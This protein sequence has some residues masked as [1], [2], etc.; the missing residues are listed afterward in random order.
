[1]SSMLEV[2]DSRRSRSKSPGGRERSRSR[3][4]SRDA[5][6]DFDRRERDRSSDHRRSTKYSGS[7]D[8]AEDERRYKDQRSSR[9]SY[10]AEEEDDRRK[11][12]RTSRAYE[13]QSEDDRYRSSK[14]GKES[15]RRDWSPSDDEKERRRTTSKRDSNR[16]RSD[17][18][19]NDDRRK[20]NRKH[21]DDSESHSEDD[22][23]KYTNGRT[24]SYSQQPAHGYVPPPGAYAEI[25]PK[26]SH[27][28]SYGDSRYGPPG[29]F[30]TSSGPPPTQRTPSY[31]GPTAPEYAKVDQYKYA[32]PDANASYKYK[33][34]SSQ[35]QYNGRRQEYD[36]SRPSD[37][38]RIKEK[39]YSDDRYE[40]REPHERKYYEDDD[41]KDHRRSSKYHSDKYGAP[42]EDM[43]KNL[44]KLAFAGG[45]G[46]ATLGVA[47]QIS[48]DG[49]KPPASPLLEAYKG[50]Y[51]SISPMPTAL[52]LANHK[53]D[54]DLSD[55]DIGRDDDSDDDIKRK[56][57]KLEREKAEYEASREKEREKK[58]AANEYETRE[59]RSSGGLET[60]E[61]R[62]RRLSN[63]DTSLEVREPGG[64]RDRSRDRRGTN[65][66]ISPT[67]PSGKKKVSF[68][69][70]TSD[71][72]RIAKALQGTGPA[73]PRP[74]LQILPGLTTDE[75]FAL[76][77]EYKNHAKVQGQGINIA[78]H[79]KMRVPGNLGKACYTTAL[80]RWESE[81]YWANSFYQGGASRREL[82]IESLMGRSNHD[83][84]EIKNC[85]KDKK[86]GDDLERCIRT[87]LRA[88]KFRMAILL[89]LEERR[90]PESTPLDPRLIKADVGAL[91]NALDSQGG[92]SDMLKIIVLRSDM[93][94]REVLRIFEGTYGIHFARAMI[95]KSRN[96][97]GETLAHILNGALNRPMR[98]A[99]L[100]RQAISETAPGKERTELL[101]SRL[102]RLHWEPKHLDKVKQVYQERYHVAVR[103]AIKREVWDGMRTPEG[104]LCAEFCIELADS[105]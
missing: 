21:R 47:T 71:A 75:L 48:H 15:R 16:K 20:S 28:M 80:G 78:K 93:H 40:T 103:Q 1:M 69:D 34:S 45:L 82:L 7:D 4:H 2:R 83:I 19:D 9:N 13:G 57:R 42:T 31:S 84:K 97:V 70:P 49:G 74:L 58:R 99:L 46:A 14:P 61:P 76:R 43:T 23:R 90:M 3:S 88:D 39:K 91:Y 87:E 77:A 68:Y 25:R 29:A 104:K 18:D 56:I 63:L 11:S 81:A 5:R 12:T 79:I 92:E 24:S 52:V 60:R 55:L 50:T 27:H 67:T 44:S 26:D 73:D 22:R 96:L 94:L 41:D 10:Y 38:D 101:I 102:V 36:R 30:P 72:Q 89:A 85:F 64:V 53:D 33:D 66:I 17:S 51:Q 6:G 62:S 86:Y 54:S 105:T 65:D 8:D 32:Q 59:P 95:S 35:P 100:L 98:D 37:S